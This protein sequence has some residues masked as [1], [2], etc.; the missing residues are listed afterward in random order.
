MMFVFSISLPYLFTIIAFQ[1]G[2]NTVLNWNQKHTTQNGVI[3]IDACTSEIQS[4]TDVQTY[5]IYCKQ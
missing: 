1:Y 4:E 2:L 3:E 5:K